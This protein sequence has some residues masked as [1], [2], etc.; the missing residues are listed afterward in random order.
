MRGVGGLLA[1]YDH[2]GKIPLYGFG[3]QYQSLPYE[4]KTH[5]F[6]MNGDIFDP[7][8]HGIENCIEHY[9][10]TLPNI[11]LFGPT[12]FEDVLRYMDEFARQQRESQWN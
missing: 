10:N 4:P 8:V 1:Q 2:N 7:E 11:R 12:N 6:A 3:C 5:C 9:K